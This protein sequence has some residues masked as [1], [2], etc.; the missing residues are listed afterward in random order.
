VEFGGWMDVKVV[1]K[2]AYS[3]KNQHFAQNQTTLSM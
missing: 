3:N 1:L 2:I